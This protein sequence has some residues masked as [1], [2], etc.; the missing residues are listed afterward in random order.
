MIARV[1]GEGDLTDLLDGTDPY[2]FDADK[3]ESLS[4]QEAE[5][6]FFKALDLDGDQALSRD[7]LSRYPGPLRELRY[8]DA[9]AAQ[10]FAHADKNRDGHVALREFRLEDPEWRALDADAD[11]ALRLVEPPYA[12]QRERGLVLP[13]S[14]W[15]TR[16][17][18][19]VPLPPGLSIEAVLKTFDRDGDERLDQRELKG[20]P[21]LLLSFDADRDQQV[22]RD[23]IAAL[24][25][26]LDDLGVLAL[27]DDFLGRWDLDGS[28]AVD[29]DELPRGVRLRLGLE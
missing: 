16:R 8:G 28:G 21:D 26:R 18:D 14:E 7:E 2:A 10:L 15:P 22:S 13:G 5:R 1:L 19:L 3:D 24:L 23:E 20:R 12:F 4:R 25:A 6:G 27:P 11:G 17:T 9:R 29:A